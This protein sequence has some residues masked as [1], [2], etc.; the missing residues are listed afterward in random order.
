M[1]N[2]VAALIITYNEENNI[3]EA[4]KSVEFCDEII[5]I[6]SFSTD[7]TIQIIQNNF[8]EVKIVQNVFEN[9]S[10]QRN[11]AIEKT[12][13]DWILFIDAD[14]RITKKLEK[15]IVKTIKQN[16]AK[17]IYFIK[18][19]FFYD[20]K[21]IHYSG[22]QND[23]NARLVK[24]IFAHYESNKRVHERIDT[25]GKIGLLKNKMLHYSFE[26]YEIYKSKVEKYAFLK[27]QDLKD[28]G[29]KYNLFLQ[30]SKTIFSFIQMYLLKLGILDGKAGFIL[31]YLSAYTTFKTFSFLKV[32]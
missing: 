1:I 25:N 13:K 30:L 14:E 9:Y 10:K 4:I 28:K 21:P 18:R 8:P 3:K 12:K 19:Q 31:S 24:K 22:T 29:K 11:F 20:K 27:A 6:D 7:N 16:T 5:V 26:S 17:D 23:K 15:E 2:N 32:I